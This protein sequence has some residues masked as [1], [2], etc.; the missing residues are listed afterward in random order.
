VLHYLP[1][2]AGFVPPTASELF[3]SQYTLQGDCEG[4]NTAYTLTMDEMDPPHPANNLTALAD[5]LITLG[6]TRNPAA[7]DTWP[8]SVG[9]V[10]KRALVL[11]PTHDATLS[12]AEYRVR[13][14]YI[15]GDLAGAAASVSLELS[16]ESEADASLLR[17]ASEAQLTVTLSG[18]VTAAALRQ[19]S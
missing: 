5:R 6:T 15:L 18:A 14:M 3:R 11:A 9:L 7:N 17:A 19:A 1:V 13:F 4:S 12:A 2:G 16:F 8:L 10:T